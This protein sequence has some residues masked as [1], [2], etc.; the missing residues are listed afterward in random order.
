MTKTRIKILLDIEIDYDELLIQ[1][2][3]IPLEIIKFIEEGF[4]SV[5]GGPDDILEGVFFE[6][7]DSYEIVDNQKIIH[8]L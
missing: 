2:N 6:K 1:K 3:D 4:Y 8:K 5:N 7:I